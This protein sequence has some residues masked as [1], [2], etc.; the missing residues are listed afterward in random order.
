MWGLLVFFMYDDIFR[1]MNNWYM[2][3]PIM[4]I[5]IFVGFCFIIGIYKNI[6]N[7]KIYIRNR[8]NLFT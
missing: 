1:W 4:V 2:F 5:V 6:Y 3:Y 8:F 7:Y